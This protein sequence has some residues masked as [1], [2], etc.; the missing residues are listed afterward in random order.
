M[1]SASSDKIKSERKVD[2]HGDSR[3]QRE[4]KDDIK[5]ERKDTR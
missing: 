2:G 5:N 3:E 1:R 4:K